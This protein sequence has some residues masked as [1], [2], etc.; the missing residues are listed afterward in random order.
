MTDS[1]RLVQ[2][3]REE[4]QIVPGLKLTEAQA[5]RLWSV[6]EAACRDA[7]ASLVAEGLVWLA[8][9][10]RYLALPDSTPSPLKADLPSARCPHCQRRN[11]VPHE[12]SA[13]E[14]V[15]QVTLRCVAC[16]RVFTFRN[17]AA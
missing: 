3:I 13:R 17:T 8:P 7:F 14:H 16:Q 1:S 12:G 6:P 4:Y 11:V 15:V 10:G 2:R 9:S 5:A